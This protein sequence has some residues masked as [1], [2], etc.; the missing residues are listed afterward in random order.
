MKTYRSPKIEVR[1]DTLSGRGVVATADIVKDALEIRP[2]GESA[3]F[4]QDGLLAAPPDGLTLVGG[5]GTYAMFVDMGDYIFAAG[6][7]AGIPDRIDSLREVAGD[8][9]IK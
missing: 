4:V 6:G 2:H 3:G 7:T 5:N 9:P 8:K 1:E